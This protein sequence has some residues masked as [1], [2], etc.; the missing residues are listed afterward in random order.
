MMILNQQGIGARIA[1]LVA[2]ATFLAV[3]TAAIA[4][5]YFQSLTMLHE[6][7]KA[8]QSTAYAM[9]SATAE[10]TAENNRAKAL[11][12]LTAVKRIDEIV[13]AIIQNKKGDTLAS[14]G[15][16][17][18]LDTNII[19]PTDSDF[20]M[21]FK[22][23]IPI[24]VDIVKGGEV[25]G[26]FFVLGDIRGLR[27][28][29]LLA[30]FSTFAAAFVAA[31]FA[32]YA[33]KP[34]Q[35]RIVGPIADMTKSIEII[36]STRNYS[37]NLPV[38]NNS[39]E[40]TVM[41][42]AFN[43][44]M[45]DIR[46]RDKSLQDLAYND[47]LTGL[48][49]RVSFHRTMS[50]WFEQDNPEGALLLLHVQN[51]RAINDA[52]GHSIG[53]ALLMTVAAAI[54]SS[55]PSSATLARYSG[56]EFSLLL[57][58]VNTFADVEKQLRNVYL[59]FS[60]PI[61]IGDLELHV[62]LTLS[63]DIVSNAKSA[64]EALRHVDLALAEAKTLLSGQILFFQPSMAET[65]LE[66]TELGQALRQAAKAGQFE[67]HYQPQLDLRSNLITGFEAL[68]RWKH[69]E[70]GYISPA[71]FIPI[72][73]KNGIVSVIGEW[74]LKEACRQAADWAKAGNSKRIMSINVSPA[75][76]MEAGFVEK[77]RAALS[78][79]GLPPNQLCIELTESIFAGNN[80]TATILTLETMARDGI[81]L[82][83]DDFGTGYSSLGYLAK[84][85]FQ[86]IK[87]D[88]S[89]V[90]NVDKNQRKFAMLKYI[91]KLV[92]ELGMSVVA[93]GAERPEELQILNRLGANAVQGYIVAKPLPANIALQTAN[94]IDA[95]KLALTA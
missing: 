11:A 58:D 16:S 71:V 9:A 93:E 51:F 86:K 88:R 66:T 18:F 35:R 63:A 83:L 20:S 77:V 5:T 87:I 39:D 43:G 24:S 41:I 47:P 30:L 40:T 33:S 81:I 12:G 55:L 70:R 31:F 4:Q 13:V 15:Q 28:Q 37:T 61:P 49:N 92:Q 84:L 19:Q 23:Y 59:A 26:K 36:K 73:E 2:L 38:Q 52:F 3:M 74:V 76:I 75:Q 48:A 50:E 69:P 80:Y 60:K 94:A 67:L 68:V 46:Y 17:A 21:L 79:S 85:P 57:P 89:F 91:V 53:D 7:K 90:S 34:L 25:I 6:H 54:K 8:M 82:A 22:G 32:V 27:S 44:M 65:L 56:D 10:A 95:E 64:D 72:A 45:S 62:S 78:E 29:Q 1:R 42:N 14:M